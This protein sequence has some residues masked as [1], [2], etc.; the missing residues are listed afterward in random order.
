MKPG[1]RASQ[2]ENSS[3]MLGKDGDVVMAVGN[4]KS[5]LLEGLKLISKELSE[6]PVV[7]T[8]SPVL[9]KSRTFPYPKAW[10]LS[11]GP[12]LI[13]V[14]MERLTGS[15]IMYHSRQALATSS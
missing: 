13:R 2:V 7:V 9:A 14:A 4:A 8:A 3:T 5:S 11:Q 10:I 6:G 12:P 15:A 1:V